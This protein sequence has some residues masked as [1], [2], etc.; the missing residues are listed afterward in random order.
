MTIRGTCLCGGVSF[1]I[2]RAVGPAE[3]CH[4]NRCRKVSGSN[5]LLT[6]R[7]RREDYRL[8]S[9]RE[10]IRSYAAPVLYG[11][12]AYQS[13]FCSNC[14]SPVPEISSQDEFLEI[15][16]GA[17][18]DDP[19]IRPDKHIFVEFMPC[20]DVLTAELPAYTRAEIYKL[21]TGSDV[22]KD[23]LQWHASSHPPNKSFPT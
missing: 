17:F 6:F 4:C 9:G 22:P 3:F 15:P 11:P 19:G 12:P 23:E 5:A 14:G 21:R 13:T 1:E 16:A 18:D 7:V 20:W 8:L 2:D 10:L